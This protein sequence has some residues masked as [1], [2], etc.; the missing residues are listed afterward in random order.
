MGQMIKGVLQKPRELSK[1]VDVENTLSGI[2]AAIESEYIEC[3]TFCNGII[4]I[5]DEEGKLNNK[6]P[7]VKYRND[8]LCGTVLFV[9]AVDD[10]FASLSNREI[11]IVREWLILNAV[12]ITV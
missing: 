6:S 2:R 10:R 5:V 8:I 12:K 9:K 1:V 3:V 7:N 4:A 11:Q